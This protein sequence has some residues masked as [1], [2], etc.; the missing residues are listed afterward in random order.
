M[1]QQPITADVVMTPV[2]A[3]AVEETPAV[4]EPAKEKKPRKPRSVVPKVVSVAKQTA[5]RD[6]LKVTAWIAAAKMHGFLMVKN[7]RKLPKKKTPEHALVVAEKD[8]LVAEWLKSGIP[9]EY[10]VKIKQPLP[11]DQ[12]VED[13]PVEV[14][15]AIATAPV[16]SDEPKQA[17]PKRKRAPKKEKAPVAADDKPETAQPEKPKKKRAPKKAKTTPEEPKPEIEGEPKPAE[18]AEVK[19]KRK[20][21]PKKVK[22]VQKE[23][24][25]QVKAAEPLV[26]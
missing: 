9:E 13:I 6:N 15:E 26:V 8:R 21:A 24:E 2:E 25:E 16:E 5:I 3:A 11:A 12:A 20:R 4:E 22:P 19:P 18:P 17:K 7:F 14:V 10:R 23:E 1:E